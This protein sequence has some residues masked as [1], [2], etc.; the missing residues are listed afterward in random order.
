MLSHSANEPTGSGDLA[1]LRRQLELVLGGPPGFTS[2]A[3]ADILAEL[4]RNCSR[5]SLL[6]ALQR[7]WITQFDTGPDAS[8]SVSKPPPD[9][10]G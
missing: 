3:R 1:I 10:T 9:P 7:E 4:L 2:G 8:P 5:S 6:D